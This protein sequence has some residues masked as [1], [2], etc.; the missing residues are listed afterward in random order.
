MAATRQDAIND[1]LE[2]LY[3]LGFTMENS[4]SERGPMVAEVIRLALRGRARP[5]SGS[6]TN[7]EIREPTLKP[8]EL[9]ERAVEHGD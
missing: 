1:V 8:D 3:D 4:F 2:R 5:K 6:E 9:V 7:V